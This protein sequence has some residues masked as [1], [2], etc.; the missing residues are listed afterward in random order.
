MMVICCCSKG[1]SFWYD[2][3]RT[4]E[5]TKFYEHPDTNDEQITPILWIDHNMGNQ[6]ETSAAITVHVKGRQSLM[7]ANTCIETPERQHD[8]NSHHWKMEN[9][10]TPKI[11]R[12]KPY[13][14]PN[15]PPQTHVPAAQNPDRRRTTSDGSTDHQ[16]TLIP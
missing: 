1:V 12:P 13:V 14:T 11:P 15:R 10:R 5:R 9:S 8:C 2:P 16:G 3:C 7:I 4:T 6:P